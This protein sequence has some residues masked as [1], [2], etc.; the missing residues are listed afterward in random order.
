M[1]ILLCNN[2]DIYNTY[3]THMLLAIVL[4]EPESIYLI[5]LENVILHRFLY[6]SVDESVK[7]YSSIEVYSS[8]PN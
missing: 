1:N 6:M 8:F 5:S 2:Y 3:T 4:G 7:L